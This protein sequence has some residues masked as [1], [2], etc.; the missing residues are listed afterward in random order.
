MPNSDV[1]VDVGGE[2]NSLE[3]RY[4]R[5]AFFERGLQSNQL[6]CEYEV[7]LCLQACCV[8]DCPLGA[9]RNRNACTSQAIRYESDHPLPCRNAEKPVPVQLRLNGFFDGRIASIGRRP[10]RARGGQNELLWQGRHRDLSG[11]WDF[12]VD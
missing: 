6:R 11:H 7:C 9:F 2:R 1:A 4:G 3:E 10:N 5:A 8:A 12:Y